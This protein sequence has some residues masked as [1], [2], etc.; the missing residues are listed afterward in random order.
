MSPRHNRFQAL[1]STTFCR[2]HYSTWPMH[3][4]SDQP[5]AS[6]GYICFAATFTAHVV[7]C[8]TTQ[9]GK[10]DQR[11]IVS[12]VLRLLLRPRSPAI[13]A[14]SQDEGSSGMIG[15]GYA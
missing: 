13:S 10:G 11:V 1:Q 7:S 8:A 9:T 12:V 4:R 15:V 5:S 3:N 14:R 6:E 2:T